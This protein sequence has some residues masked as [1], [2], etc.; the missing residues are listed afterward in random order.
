MSD[1]LKKIE[2]LNDL[3]SRKMGNKHSHIVE[4]ETMYATA[5]QKGLVN[6]PEY[7]LPDILEMEIIF[8]RE[9]DS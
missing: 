7:S 6:K 8:R 5:L 4:M 9:K 1:L 2:E 3:M